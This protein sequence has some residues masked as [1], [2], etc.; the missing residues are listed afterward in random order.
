MGILGSIPSGALEI[1]RRVAL[2]GEGS[3]GTEVCADA[4]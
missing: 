2:L 3:D 1:L 4:P